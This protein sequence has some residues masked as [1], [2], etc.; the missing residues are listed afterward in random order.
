MDPANPAS[1]NHRTE[2]LS[3]GRR[4][5]FVDQLPASY[6]PATTKTFV[7]IHGFPD[8]WYGWRYQIKP[9]VEL[10]Y[11]VVVP[12][13]L[14]Y[15]GTDKPEDEAEYT[16]RKIC[17]DIAALMDLLQLQRAVIIGHDWG[18]F[19][20]S[21]FALWHPN[22]LLSL[23]MQLVERVPNWGY[24]LFFNDK[25][26]SAEIESKLSKFFKLIFRD[27]RKSDVRLENWT[28]TGGLARVLRSDDIQLND[29]GVLTQQEFEYYLSQF[30][31][32]MHAPLNYY[33]TTLHRFREEQGELFGYDA[34]LQAPRPDLPVLLIVGKNDPTSNQAAL[35]VTRK[36]IP[37]V[38]IELLDGAGHWLMVERKEYV[39]EIVPQFVRNAT[40]KDVQTKL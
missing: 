21:R 7:C 10:G 23:I 4:Y 19:M 26:S 16:P 12:D 35:D 11:R 18:C 20:V 37:H 5:H 13:M 31:R 36:L 25:R 39:T 15:G 34:I 27:K 17:N 14:G 29:T 6:D 22:R 9:W 30:D 1:F 28:L 8:F 33:R 3:T 38:R 40:A 24:H 32:S 2:L